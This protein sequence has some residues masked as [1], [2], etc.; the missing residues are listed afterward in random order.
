M[1]VLLSIRQLCSL[2]PAQDL[3]EDQRNI[4]IL[5]QYRQLVTVKDQEI[6][7]LRESLSQKDVIITSQAESIEDWKGLAGAK[8]MSR[9]GKA[10]LALSIGGSVAAVVGFVF[11]R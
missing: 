5:N 11:G 4:L 7:A 2:L 1:K 10:R 8:S 3:T 9:G 6:E